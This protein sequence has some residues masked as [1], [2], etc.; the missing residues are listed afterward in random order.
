VWRGKVTMNS[1]NSFGRVSTSIVPPCCFT[2]MSQNRISILLPRLF[3]VALSLGSGPRSAA[4][5]RLFAAARFFSNV[6]FHLGIVHQ[7]PQAG[8]QQKDT[9]ADGPQT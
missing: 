4:S 7:D 6:R 3:V 5:I 2:T 1:V 9:P 8:W